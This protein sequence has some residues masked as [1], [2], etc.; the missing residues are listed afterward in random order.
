VKKSFSLMALA[1]FAAFSPVA[2]ADGPLT[3]AVA[4]NAQ[5]AMEEVAAVFTGETGIPV[6]AVVGSSGKLTA[7][8]KAGAPFD[9]FVSADTS[10]PKALYDD[11]I[12]TAP[13]EVY[14]SGTLVVWS[15]SDIN[16]SGGLSS[17]L[18]EKIRRVAV[19]NPETA[20]YGFA[21]VKA[22]RNAG[23][24]ERIKNKLVFG[25]SISQ[26][27]QFVFAK[28]AEA[29][30]TAK[31]SL[32]SPGMAGKGSW[33]DVDGSLYTPIAQGIV[34]LKYGAKNNPSAVN[35]LYSYIFSSTGK[36]ILKKYGYSTP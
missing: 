28:A 20:P 5:F 3:V 17:L 26:V 9:I 34:V 14:A 1:A 35:K 8:I 19:A 31:S 13:P 29:G 32:M 11:G 27:N 4:A 21:A 23:I 25:E 22:L 30:V 15:A 18:S 16:I 12:A 2:R 24:Y 6:R 36:T 10:Y 33:V 7:Q